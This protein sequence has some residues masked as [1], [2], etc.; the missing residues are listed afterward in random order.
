MTTP[1]IE[2][3]VEKRNIKDL[4]D[5]HKNP[6]K[7]TKEQAKDLQE[8]LHKFGVVGKP[9]INLDNVIIGGHQRVRTLKKMGHKEIEV[10]V[11]NRLLDEKEV[12]ELNIR[13]NRNTGSFDDDMLANQFDIEDLIDWGF[14]GEYFEG[15]HKEEK[16]EK[17][18]KWK[19]IFEFS[20]EDDVQECL[21]GPDG[22]QEAAVRWGATLKV[23]L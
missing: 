9:F 23:K 20:S 4:K 7:M 22:M 5:Y 11:P 12:E 14:S 21:L 6:R 18:K 13:H 2:W 8:S 17:A 16:T 15:P 3:H 10:E 19:A 1:K